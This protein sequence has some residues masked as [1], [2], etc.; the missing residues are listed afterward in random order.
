MNFCQYCDASIPEK[1]KGYK[2]RKFCDK[3]CSR[4]YY[5]NNNKD[6]ISEA[7]RKG[8]ETRKKTDPESYKRSWKM[9]SKRKKLYSSL[10]E[11][12][13]YKKMG[14]LGAK[15]A[16]KNQTIFGGREHVYQKMVE[17]GKWFDY[18][19]FNYD[20]VKRY[21]QS[22]RRLT[23]KYYGSAGEG[24]HWD[25]IVPIYVGYKL[26]IPPET[27]C[28]GENIRK[29][30]KEKNLSKGNKM[31]EESYEILKKWNIKE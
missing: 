7:T 26:E 13:H 21:T 19:L 31:I 29:I 14:K 23:L 27:M 25:H 1:T 4:K 11:T 24:Y 15:S 6:L 17:N 18:S 5:I 2:K 28:S 8:H 30:S 16:L 22:V 10:K 3:S 20:D 9:T 12:G